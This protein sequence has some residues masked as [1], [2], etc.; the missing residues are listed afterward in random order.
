MVGPH[1]SKK[2]KEHIMEAKDINALISPKVTV[3]SVD[4]NGVTKI[5]IDYPAPEAVV[6]EM[7]ALLLEVSTFHKVN[8]AL[9]GQKKYKLLDFYVENMRRIIATFNNEATIEFYIGDE[10]EEFL[11]KMGVACRHLEQRTGIANLLQFAFAAKATPT[12]TESDDEPNNEEDEYT[13]WDGEIPDLSTPLTT[14]TPRRS[15]VSG[16]SR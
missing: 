7:K 5:E 15:F 11:A 6:S 9:E 1:L 13:G 16:F 3:I 12:T 2:E 14:P 4:A 10:A 8:D